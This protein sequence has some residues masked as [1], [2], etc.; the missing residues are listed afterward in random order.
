MNNINKK[1]AKIRENI[2]TLGLNNKFKNWVTA[3]NNLQSKRESSTKAS[4]NMF[5]N[6]TRTGRLNR[7]T[8]HNQIEAVLP[9]KLAYNKQS[10]VNFMNLNSAAREM[11][12]SE[13]SAYFGKKL[14]SPQ[15]KSEYSNRKNA[16]LKITSRAPSEVSTE[17]STSAG[18]AFRQKG[19]RSPGSSSTYPL[20]TRLAGRAAERNGVTPP[21]SPRRGSSRTLI[22]RVTPP[23]SETGTQSSLASSQRS[24]KGGSQRGSASSVG[25]S[26]IST[27]ERKATRRKEPATESNSNIGTLPNELTMNNFRN[28][29]QKKV[30]EEVVKL[31]KMKKLPSKGVNAYFE[32]LK[33]NLKQGVEVN[34]QGVI[35]NIV[36][37]ELNNY[38][39]W[40][41]KN[42]QE[43]PK[44]LRSNPN[45]KQQPRYMINAQIKKYKNRLDTVESSNTRNPKILLNLRNNITRWNPTSNNKKYKNNYLARLKT[46]SPVNANKLRKNTA[47]GKTSTERNLMLR[48]PKKERERKQVKK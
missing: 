28:T 39:L 3:Y 23:P 45:L 43:M 25:T 32:N 20:P 41:R 37:K 30:G 13:Y 21:A 22:R 7:E 18:K 26:Q 24:L 40:L 34:N 10:R 8:L 11:F 48:K 1:K 6:F 15:T 33:S 2:R 46:L 14:K 4:G 9:S 35:N 12:G 38:K 36:N 16:L 29:I 17:M 31:K 27:E 19:A 42:D 47:R 44:Q 5:S